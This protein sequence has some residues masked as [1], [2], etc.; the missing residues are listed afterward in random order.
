MLPFVISTTAVIAT[1]ALGSHYTQQSVR[2]PWYACVKPAW[3]PP[4]WVFPVVWTTLYVALAVAAGL[5]IRDDPAL[6]T[7]LHVANLVLNVVWCRT[8]FGQKDVGTGIGVIVGNVGV[9][10]TIAL[11]TRVDVVRWLMVP[12]IA[13]L[14]F[15]TSLNVGAWRKSIDCSIRLRESV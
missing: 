11:L 7:G 6:L 1:A 5:S 12:Y 2:G 8:F 13:W 3:A 4:S 10:V 14:L 9:A 15:A